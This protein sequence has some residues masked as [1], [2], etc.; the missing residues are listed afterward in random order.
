MLRHWKDVKCQGFV[1]G[2]CR[3]LHAVISV[4]AL[5]GVS[6]LNCNLS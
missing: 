4:L 3:I 6:Q 1:K 2:W 5:S